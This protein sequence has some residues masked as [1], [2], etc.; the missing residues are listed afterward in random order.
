LLTLTS[1]K[2]SERRR[3]VATAAAG[4]FGIVAVSALQTFSGLA[5]FDMSALAV[6][7]ALVSVVLLLTALVKLLLALRSAWTP[8]RMGPPVGLTGA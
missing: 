7:I 6:A 4:Y 2:D 1:M 8:G 5:P 3:I